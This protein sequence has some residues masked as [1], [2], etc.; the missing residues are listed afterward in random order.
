MHSQLPLALFCHPFSFSFQPISILLEHLRT[1]RNT[2]YQRHPGAILGWEWVRWLLLS[3][4][5]LIWCLQTCSLSC[6][7]LP[8]KACFYSP[9]L[10]PKS[11]A[12]FFPATLFSLSLQHICIPLWHLPTSRNTL[13]HTP[14]SH[15][16]RLGLWV[17]N[18]NQRNNANKDETRYL[19]R[20]LQ[21]SSL[22]MPRS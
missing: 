19:P 3:S 4:L 2:F 21:T 14:H 10:F 6:Y 18:S 12:L 5:F 22:Q 9:C 11:S 15:H 13:Y 16:T 7:S 20:I 17:S 8:E 1:L